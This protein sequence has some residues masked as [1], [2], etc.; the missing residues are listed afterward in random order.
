MSNEALV[1]IDVQQGM[2]GNPANQPHDGEG[3]V[4]RLAGLLQR[5]R[6]SGTPVFFVQHDGGAETPL[7]LDSPGFAYREE[8]TPLPTEDVTVKKH[9]SVFQDTDFADKLRAAGVDHLIIGGMQSEFCVDTAVRGAFERGFS[10][11]LISDGHTTFG[12]STLSGEQVI[13]HH[14][15]TLGGGSF[16]ELVLASD[17]VMTR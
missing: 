3:V 8:L 13:A 11:T 5:V 14:N 12:T 9:C 6:A 17:V 7:A 1:I 16:A 4:A 15:H 10:V 2:F